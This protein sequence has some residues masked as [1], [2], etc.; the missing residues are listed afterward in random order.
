MRPF[1]L[2]AIFVIGL[3]LPAIAQEQAA[4]DPTAPLP[5]IDNAVGQCQIVAT[6]SDDDTSISGLCIAATEQLL[7]GL[8][9]RDPAV[10]DQTITD[11]VVAIAPLVQDET[12]NAGD[13]EIAQAVR[14]A[15]AA[16]STPEQTA[17]LI[18]IA[19]TIEACE[20]SQT[21]QTEPDPDPA[22]AA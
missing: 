22:S 9:G 14:L 18:E 2:S 8:E 10:V 5:T 3:S 4:I 15:A 12:C 19:E 1:V 13:E 7:D 11:L 6:G 17:R 21:A 20:V 16:S